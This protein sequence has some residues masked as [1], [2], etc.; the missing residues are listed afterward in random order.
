MQTNQQTFKF[1]QEYLHSLNIALCNNIG[2][3]LE[4]LD[5]EMMDFRNYKSGA[6]P[7]H[8]GD[9]ATG[10]TIYPENE[11]YGW[12]QCNTNAC[13]KHFKQNLIGFIYGVLS[14]RKGWTAKNK[15]KVNFGEVLELCKAMV[16]HVKLDKISHKSKLLAEVKIKEVKNSGI[17][18]EDIRKK[19]KIPSPF[20]EKP[21]NGGF[22]RETLNYFDV[23]EGPIEGMENRAIVPIYDESFFVSGFQGRHLSGGLPKWKNSEGLPLESIL[24]NYANAKAEIKKTKEVIIVEGAKGVWRL[25]EVGIRNCVAS[26]GNFK[27]GQKI[28]LEMSGATTIKTMFDNDEPG[29]EFHEALNKKCRRL[30]HVK[31]IEYGK[32]GQDPADLSTEEIKEMSIGNL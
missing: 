4:Y 13:H 5:I 23:G 18:R 15:Q 3:V 1:D 25:W 10:L 26:L 16:G 2:D 7:I 9:N 32:L 21:E 24:Y 22:K 19:I 8:G 27:N 29:R 11:P 14:A 30:F 28:L 20:F 17:S 31:R 6:C 12:W